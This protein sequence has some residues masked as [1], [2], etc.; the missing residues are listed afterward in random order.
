[1]KVVT[2]TDPFGIASDTQIAGLAGAIDPVIAR[3]EF[4]R[5]LPRLSEDGKL[6]LKGVRVTRHKPGR[7]CVLEYDLRVKRPGMN[8]SSVILIGKIR[9]R[10]SGNE[11]FRLQE[12]IW[13]AGFQADSADGISVPEPIGVIADFNMWFQRKVPGDTAE[14]L[15]PGPRGVQ[16]ARRVAEAIHK[17]HR[18]NVPADKKHSLSDELR[19]LDTCLTEVATFHPEWSKRL[20]ELLNAC[21]ALEHSIPASVPCGIHRDFYPAQVIVEADR[22]WLIDFDLYCLGDPALDAGN[23]I[24]H[25]TEQALREH[26]RADALAEIEAALEN[27]FIE[28]SGEGMRGAVRAYTNLTLVRHIYLSTKHPERFAFTEALLQL[29]ERRLL[30]KAC[31]D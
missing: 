21:R 12:A 27:R 5:R 30:S 1:M 8:R 11:A 22:L 29:C 17:L 23:F 14:R 6:S 24:G 13:N 4:K 16:I 18:A 20:K 15:L 7:R 28:L 19:I 3:K 25:I 2:L 10:H 31:A 26:G 9:A